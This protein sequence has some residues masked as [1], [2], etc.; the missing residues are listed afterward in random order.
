MPRVI[1]TVPGTNPQPY[2]F[3]LDRKSVTLGRGSMNDIVVDCGSVSVKHAEMRRVEGGYELRDLGSTNGLKVHGQTRELVPLHDG[4]TVRIGDVAFEFRLSADELEV[5]S[6][7][8]PLQESPIIREPVEPMAAEPL[9][10]ETGASPEPGPAQVPDSK[11]KTSKHKPQP[12]KT[13]LPEGNQFGCVW[14]FWTLLIAAIAFGAGM[15]LRYE[16]GTG[17]S[18][19][20][21][22]KERFMPTPPSSPAPPQAD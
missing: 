12:A 7:E 14:L 20:K 15:M 4:D 8:R 3:Q 18:W 17:E 21:S 5:I 13:G 2:L 11:R 9:E 16:R 19:L 10:S 22:V 1:I 6:R